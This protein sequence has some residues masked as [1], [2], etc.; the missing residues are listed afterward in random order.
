M[1]NNIDLVWWVELVLMVGV[2]LFFG[3]IA[4]DIALGAPLEDV[5]AFL[6]NDTT[7]GSEWLPYY[8]CGHFARDLSRNAST[9]NISIGSVILGNHPVL[10][11]HD[12]HALNY[13]IDNNIVYLI[14]PQT[15]EI[16]LLNQSEYL[17]Y[18]LYP[19]GDQVPSYWVHNLATKNIL[20]PAF[21][22]S[23]LN[24]D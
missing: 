2:I 18:R 4:C 21:K 15:D 7:N 20:P 13:V 24:D 10:R 14:E 1:K 17:Y 19:N 11:G 3:V 12:N 22:G 6:V 8:S 23:G 5:E 16:Y 9:L